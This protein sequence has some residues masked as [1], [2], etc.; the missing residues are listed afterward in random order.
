MYKWMM[1]TVLLKNNRER[2]NHPSVGHP[3]HAKGGRKGREETTQ[4]WGNFVP[5]P[6]RKV[7]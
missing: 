1:I 4:Q 7:K 5:L 6:T 2:Q 3:S